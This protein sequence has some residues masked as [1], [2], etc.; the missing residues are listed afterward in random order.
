MRSN[1]KEKG[2][3]QTP[4]IGTRSFSTKPSS[5]I[6]VLPFQ[7]SSKINPSLK[8]NEGATLSLLKGWGG[9]KKN[10]AARGPETGPSCA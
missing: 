2:G 3:A 7:K 4:P 1:D 5:I 8:K 9:V 10:F 6:V